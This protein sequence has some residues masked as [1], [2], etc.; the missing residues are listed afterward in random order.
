MSRARTPRSVGAVDSLT[1]R[2]R[3]IAKLAALGL[4]NGQVAARLGVTAAVVQAALEAL[5]RELRDGERADGDER[6][7]MNERSV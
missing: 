3:Q 7:A 2:Q 1:P 6:R 5:Y 4:E